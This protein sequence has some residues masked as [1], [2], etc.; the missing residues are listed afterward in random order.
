M[1]LCAF[2]SEPFTLLLASASS[3]K[4]SQLPN[5]KELIVYSSCRFCKF[6]NAPYFGIQDSA[7][8][9]IFK[10]NQKKPRSK[11]KLFVALYREDLR[12]AASSP[13]LPLSLATRA[14]L[15]YCAPP[16][17][18]LTPLAAA[19]FAAPSAQRIEKRLRVADAGSLKRTAVHGPL[20]GF[21]APGVPVAGAYAY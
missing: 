19:A 3:W 5:S 7:V 1:G 4:S 11:N 10:N 6:Y 21:A 8:G 14:L 9:G 16:L 20:S 12:P 18:S 13:A 17:P 15:P 2:S